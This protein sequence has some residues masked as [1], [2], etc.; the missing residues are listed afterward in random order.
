[1]PPLSGTAP[2]R[3]I[4]RHSYVPVTE[5]GERM[6]R[7]NYLSGEECKTSGKFMILIHTNWLYN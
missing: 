5:N 2:K 7:K 3:R 4:Q 6:P 1:M